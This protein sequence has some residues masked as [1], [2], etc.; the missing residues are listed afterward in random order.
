MDEYEW[1]DL[2]AHSYR[3]GNHCT[4]RHNYCSRIPESK[5]YDRDADSAWGRGVRG[6]WRGVIYQCQLS[7]QPKR[8]GCS[9]C[10]GKMRLF[11]RRRLRGIRQLLGSLSP[12]SRGARFRI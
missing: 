1:D 9:L 10:M 3:G 6:I 2:A 8:T 4:L 7:I 12:L 5:T 11:D